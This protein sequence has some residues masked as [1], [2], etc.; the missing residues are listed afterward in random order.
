MKKYNRKQ[1]VQMVSE[2]TGY[3]E[4]NVA[5]IYTALEEIINDLQ[6]TVT[7]KDNIE[8]RPFY[9][10]GLY[11]EFVPEHDKRMPDGTIIHIEDSVKFSARYSKKWK[12][13][14][15]KLYKETQ[16]LWKRVKE[17]MDEKH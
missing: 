10:L 2:K 15:N 3:E 5:E 1:L 16:A 12:Y 13:S 7:E 4:I 9:G 8:I 14:R 6:M 11:T 17:K